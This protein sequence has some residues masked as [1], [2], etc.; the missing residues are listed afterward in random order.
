MQ[1]AIA[2]DP[3]YYRVDKTKGLPSN[4]V[5]DIFQDSKGFIWFATGSGLCRYDGYRFAT[6]VS[7]EQTLKAGSN[8]KEDKYGRIWYMNFDG[9]I[10]YVE[11]DSLHSFK[12]STVWGYLRFGL[13]DNF[14]YCVEPNQIVKYDLKTFSKSVSFKLST[15]EVLA[16]F[17]D[18][19]Y[20]YVLSNAIYRFSGKGYVDK[21]SLPHNFV[22]ELPTPILES[23]NGE[24]VIASKNSKIYFRSENG[25]FV[26]EY[27]SEDPKFIQNIKYA[28]NRLWFCTTNGVV[29]QI[30]D[31]MNNSVLL[32]Y[33]ESINTTTVFQD[34]AGTIWLGTI[35]NGVL[36]INDFNSRYYY[37]ES[38]VNVVDTYKKNVLAGVANDK[39]LLFDK[40]TNILY[41]GDAGHDIYFLY[42]DSA[43]K[44]IFATSNRFKVLNEKGELLDDVE[45][46]VKDVVAVRDGDFAFAATGACGIIRLKKNEKSL[47]KLNYTDKQMFRSAVFYSVVNNVRGK[48][49]AYD[50]SKNQVYFATNVGLYLWV[51]N[52]LTEIKYAS[53]KSVFY[54]Q[55]VFWSN[56]LW[57]LSSAGSVYRIDAGNRVSKV[58]VIGNSE[59]VKVRSLKIINGKMYVIVGNDMYRYNESSG[60]S[61]KLISLG[62]DITLNDV[63]VN[64]SDFLIA[65]TKGVLMQDTAEVLKLTAPGLVLNNMYVDDRKIKNITD[66]QVF[67][68]SENNILIDYSII[69]FSP[70]QTR[71]LLYRVN[72]GAWLTLQDERHTIE[73]QNLPP[74]DYVVSMKSSNGQLFSKVTEVRFKIAQPFWFQ[75]WFI[76][77]LVILFAFLVYR[78]DKWRTKRISKRS[79]EIIE[80]IN[81]EKAANLSKL[82]AIKSQMN[83][84]FFFNALNTIQ[85]FILENDK[86]QAVNVL[87]KFSGLTRSILEMSDKDEV[88]VAEEIRVLKL[89][90]DIEKVR[91]NDDF[92]YEI[93]VNGFDPEEIRIPSL[94][95]QPYVENAIK[96][97]LL[98]KQGIKQL[99]LDFQALP[100]TLRIIISDNGIGRKMSMELNAIK[101]KN[102]KS[103]ATD[104]TEQRVKLLNEFTGREITL[105]YI[106]E[107]SD[108]GQ[109]LGTTVLIKISLNQHESNNN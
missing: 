8:I 29:N 52:R 56:K 109:P 72:G 7:D 94:L 54:N 47:E 87:S 18:G 91:F 84:H 97:G 68:S 67:K 42:A 39:V 99:R 62:N 2:Q 53:G 98:H 89:Y 74:G 106:D 34:N 96:H 44:N 82:K 1:S 37:I 88:S 22:N 26:K 15:N 92:E 90:L 48:S 28:D 93:F 38:G 65:T 43:S 66:K 107:F 13:L 6:Y 85:S 20:F 95:L 105:E 16:T 63:T 21:L 32:R 5:Y 61:D 23:Q 70:N 45:M 51:N 60:K 4:T 31:K 104:A 76:L 102:H 81:L 86:K 10:Y 19:Q 46:A 77:I 108:G 79:N 33:F 50:S 14:I 55:I 49:V 40:S 83:P 75:W 30:T 25:H 57:G 80:R 78:Y 11:N 9:Y 69:C 59:D 71:Q 73:L 100:E 58:D 103:F 17:S 64:G 101:A 35:G 36:R 27:F 24:L 3:F 41:K 12:Q